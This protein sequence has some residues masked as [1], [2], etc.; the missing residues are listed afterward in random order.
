MNRNREIKTNDDGLDLKSIISN[1]ENLEEYD[2]IE[3]PHLYFQKELLRISRL[4][5]ESPEDASLYR[6]RAV[7]YD[8]KGELELAIEDYSMAIEIEPDDAD[9]LFCRSM[10]SW[11]SGDLDF[12]MLD[13]NE[14][15]QIDPD[16]TDFYF[17]RAEYLAM[18]GSYCDALSDLDKAIELDYHD[19]DFHLFRHILRKRDGLVDDPIEAVKSFESAEPGCRQYWST[20][21]K[22]HTMLGQRAEAL[23]AIENLKNDSS[24]DYR[25]H[26]IRSKI[27][28]HF[29][30]Y[31]NALKELEESEGLLSQQDENLRDYELYLIRLNKGLTLLN[32]GYVKEAKSTFADATYIVPYNNLAW[33]YL[34]WANIES[35]KPSDAVS[36]FSGSMEEYDLFENAPPYFFFLFGIAL[37]MS[38]SFEPAAVLLNLTY[39]ALKAS[40]SEFTMGEWME[41]E[42]SAIIRDPSLAEKAIAIASKC[43]DGVLVRSI[44]AYRDNGSLPFY[45]KTSDLNF[46]SRNVL[47]PRIRRGSASSRQ[48]EQLRMPSTRGPHAEHS[49]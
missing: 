12:A 25:F 39:L 37:G 49:A 16:A 19:I 35:G 46:D 13:I 42:Q 5:E 15:I 48:L 38:K 7:F 14:A 6:R 17:K 10:L 3:E 21:A 34:G 26:I 45:N 8:A 22:E 28:R 9:T 11:S 31:E 44:E 4:I 43:G 40:I 36:D 32:A 33:S 20:L 29:G 1:A 24:S 47:D 18:N 30:D 41:F 2:D 27:L 23:E